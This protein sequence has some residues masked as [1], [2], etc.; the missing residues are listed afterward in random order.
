MRSANLRNLIW[1]TLVVLHRYLGVTVGLLMV[2]W[3][4]SGI[5]MMYA[6][7]PPITDEERARTLEPIQPARGG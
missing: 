3:F 2:I 7:L 4:A 1:Q 5:V 6:G